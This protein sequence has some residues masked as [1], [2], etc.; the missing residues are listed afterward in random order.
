[1]SNEVQ[2]INQFTAAA[3]A[4]SSEEAKACAIQWLESTGNLKKFTESQKNQFI[5]ICIAYRLDPTKKEVYGIPYGD[6]FN[7]IV[8]Y[9]VY[10]KRAERSGRLNGWNVEVI[11]SGEEMKAV[12]T[13]YRKDWNQPFKHEV[14]FSE[15]NTNQN[16]WKSKPRTMIK[17]VA[18][19]Q[20][21]RMCFSEEL[22]GIP[23]TA[24]ELPEEMSQGIDTSKLADEALKPAKKVENPDLVELT[25]ILTEST[26]ASGAL[27]FTEEDKTRAKFSIKE[28]GVKATL[29]DV[30][31]LLEMRISSEVEKEA[32]SQ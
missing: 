16:L 14:Y 17:K 2:V 7:L 30:K 26:Y 21:F 4:L 32:L 1:M 20:G 27:I 24:E 8:A 22:G 3:P 15:Y 18:I 29:A 31:E 10:I 23:Y 9:D 28:H 11:G 13:I 25:K 12:I 6:K 19:A 5:D